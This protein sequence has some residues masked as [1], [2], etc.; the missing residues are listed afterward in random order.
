MIKICL[1]G[2]DVKEFENGTTIYEV[3]KVAGVSLATVSRV[4]NKKENV[5]EETKVR[6]MKAAKLLIENHTIE[7]ISNILES[8]PDIIYRDLTVRLQ[9]IDVDE[10]ILIAVT[11]TLKNH[12]LQ[13]LKQN[14]L[15]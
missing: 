9:K 15:K 1:R 11:A 8:T 13:N 14:K 3:A 5:T 7:E 4:I 6:V 10:A 12:S 2:T